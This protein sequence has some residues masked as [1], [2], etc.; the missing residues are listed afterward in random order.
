MAQSLFGDTPTI[1]FADNTEAVYGA[2]GTK[3]R[4]GVDGVITGLRY[5]GP[6]NTPAPALPR[7]AIWTAAGVELF[8]EDFTAAFVPSGWNTLMFS[9]P[10]AVVAGDVRVSAS[11]AR[12]RYAATRFVFTAELVVGN[13]AGIEGSFTSGAVYAFPSNTSTTWYGV[14]TIFEPASSFVRPTIVVSPSGAA[15]RAGSW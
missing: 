1:E 13:L 3:V 8:G 7:G 10:Q 14:D 12:S 4:Y 9:S 2:M 11:G 6:L 5:W 15:H